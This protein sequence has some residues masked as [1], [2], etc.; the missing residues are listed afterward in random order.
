MQKSLLKQQTS[1]NW[2]LE[3]LYQ[4]TKIVKLKVVIVM[5]FSSL[6]GMLITPNSLQDISKI[7]SGISGI[8]LAACASAALNHLFDKDEDKKMQRT[9]NRPLAKEKLSPT[10]AKSFAIFS[11]ILSTGLLWTLNNPLCATLTLTTTIGYSILYTKW[12]KPTT[13]Q[14]IVIGG[15]SGAMPPLLGWCSLTG[16]ITVEPLLLVLIVF[17]WTPAHF[18]PLAIAH[19]NDYAKT[20]WPML[21]VTHGITF[22][23]LSIIAYALLTTISTL[24][25]FCIRMTGHLYL[26]VACIV[27]LRWLYLC[28]KLWQDT[29]AARALFKFSIY[30]ILIIF[31]LLL[32]D[33]KAPGP[34]V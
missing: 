20:K 13:P 34:Y 9:Q 19:K 1:P 10:T 3:Q 12:L 24:I 27:N 11:I 25:P 21:P 29:N 18:W 22:T 33:H 30:Y 2:F 5:M 7:L 6:I 31:F 4:I 17:N 14:N 23:K 28:K 8:S 26:S 15:L 32:L 16:N